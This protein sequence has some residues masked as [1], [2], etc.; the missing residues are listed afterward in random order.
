MKAVALDGCLHAGRVA[1]VLH[2]EASD[3]LGKLGM[4]RGR[5][6]NGRR[7]EDKAAR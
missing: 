6:R 7:R 2:G 3:T 1:F 5:S 4:T